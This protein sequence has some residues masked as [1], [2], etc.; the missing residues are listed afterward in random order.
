MNLDWKAGF[1]PPETPR[2]DGRLTVNSEK[3]YQAAADWAEHDMTLKPAST[4]ALR[5][6][7]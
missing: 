7:G 6:S 3:D 5:R 1:C 4:T 2:P